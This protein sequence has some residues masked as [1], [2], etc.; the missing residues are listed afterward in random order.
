MAKETN[1]GDGNLQDIISATS[2]TF[3]N[4]TVLIDENPYDD[5]ELTISASDDIV[6]NPL[7]SGIETIVFTTS[8]TLAGILNL[9]LTCPILLVLI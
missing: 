8:T 7:V 6:D 1:Y 3:V 9:I 2:D 5:D 4:G